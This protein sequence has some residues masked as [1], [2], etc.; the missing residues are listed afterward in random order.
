MP[1]RGFVTACRPIAMPVNVVLIAID[2]LRADRL[3][4]YGYPKPTTPFIDELAANGVVF[5]HHF[6]PVAPTQ[7]AFTTIY[8][9]VH[10]LTHRVVAHEGLQN[11]NP[12]CTWLPLLMRFHKWHTV[13]VDNLADHKAWFWRGFE[14]YINPRR[15]SEYPDCHVYN[16]RAREWLEHCRREPFMMTLHYWDTHTPYEPV[17]D[18]VKEFYDGDPTVTNVDS[19]KAF[20]ENPQVER[21]PALWFENLL[22]RW[23]NKSGQR[24]EDGQFIV[25]HYDACVRTADDGVREICE[26]LDRLGLFDDTLLIVYS[27]HGEELLGEHGIFFDHHGLYDSNLRC[28]LIMHWP[29]GLPGGRRVSAMTQHQDIFA[30]VLDAC[31]LPVPEDVVEG[32]SLLPHVTDQAATSHWEELL[33]ACESTWQAKW[34]MRTDGCK[35]IVSRQPDM[36]GFPPVELYDL[37][38]DPGERNNVWG[39]DREMSGRFLARFN[40]LIEQM[41]SERGLPHDL[42]SKNGLTLGKQFI[43]DHGMTYPLTDAGWSAQMAAAQAL[44]R[45]YEHSVADSS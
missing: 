18:Y 41:V 17:L 7:P 14:Y 40:R 4:C 22:A 26:R 3:G 24:I 35:L 45:N 38:V 31:G 29:R 30:T 6:T 15:R 21:W 36:H 1:L 39:V 43:E 28:P 37:R 32:R 9:G 10:P 16:E 27:D 44:A 33:L 11:P 25:A 34:A 12:K 8:S 5:E 42:V 13:A 23:P 19:L 2:A 20:Y